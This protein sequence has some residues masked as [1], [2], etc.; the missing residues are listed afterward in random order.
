MFQISRCPAPAAPEDG[1]TPGQCVDAR[2]GACCILL[3]R[4][5]LS[6]PTGRVK[7]LPHTLGCF[8]CG[9]ANPAG[10][11]LRFETDG[12][13]VQ[14]RFVPQAQHVGFR[15]TIHGGIISTVLDETMVWA[16]VVQTRRFAYCAELTVRFVN[17]VPPGQEVTAVGELVSN[18]RDRIYEAKGELKTEA[19]L[20]LAAAT[21]KYIPLKSANLRE[22]LTDFVGDPNWLL[23]AEA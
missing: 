3:V 5:F 17:P 11:K 4:P 1:R 2:V 10:L 9:E 6:W 15:G 20:V 21:G 12:R 22:M 19:G 18:R 13:R 23:G 8:V 14:T 16:C 7:T